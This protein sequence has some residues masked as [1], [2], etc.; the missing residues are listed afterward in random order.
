MFY[1]RT[2]YLDVKVNFIRDCI[3]ENQI[4]LVNISTHENLAHM[5]TKTL[6]SA[7]FKFYVNLVGL[8]NVA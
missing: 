2:K 4:E 1:D 7:K 6:P 5:L 8:Y 3:E